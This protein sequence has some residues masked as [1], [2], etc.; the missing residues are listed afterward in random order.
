MGV[1]E[2]DE[3]GLVVGYPIDGEQPLFAFEGF[4]SIEGQCQI[5]GYQ[6][7]DGLGEVHPDFD[8]VFDIDDELITFKL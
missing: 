5:Q 8:N 6:L 4:D 3:N 1:D 7:V 2:M